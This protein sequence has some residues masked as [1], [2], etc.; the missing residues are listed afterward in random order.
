MFGMLKIFWQTVRIFQY[1]QTFHLPK[2]ELHC[3]LHEKLHRLTGP[4]VTISVIVN[5]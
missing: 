4:L 5:L 1:L 3:K 2:V